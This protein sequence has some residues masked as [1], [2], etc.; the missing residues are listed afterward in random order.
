MSD[1]VW[2]KRPHLGKYKNLPTPPEIRHS[3]C[4][5]LPLAT[6]K[7]VEMPDEDIEVY[8]ANAVRTVESRLGTSLRPI[9]VKCTMNGQLDPSDEANYDIAE[10]P[11]DYNFYTYS[12]RWGALKLR[13]RPVISIDK[14]EFK[15]P[16]GQKIYDFPPEWIKLRPRQGVLHIVP[17]T[18]YSTVISRYPILAGFM[19]RNVPQVIWV[20]YTAGFKEI[21]DDIYDLIAKLTAITVLGIAGDAV[22]VGISS[23]STSIDGLSESL[24]TTAS[25]TSATY[26]AHIKQL[27]DEVNDLFDQRKG[28]IR[29]RTMGVRLT[30]V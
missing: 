4:F 5:G 25:A 13:R 8:I 6:D 29:G 11:Y 16:N 17:Y 28:D 2:K 19:G 1:Y 22:L 14:F 27:T 12:V 30:G 18:G 20:D 7:G 24:S 23:I 3:Y 9:K 26:G 15:F 10:P 21:P